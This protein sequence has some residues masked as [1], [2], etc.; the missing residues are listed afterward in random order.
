MESKKLLLAN[1]SNEILKIDCYQS[2]SKIKE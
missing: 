2:T 1:L